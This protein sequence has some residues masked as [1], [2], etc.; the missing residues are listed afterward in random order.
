MGESAKWVLGS[1]AWVAAVDWRGAF[2]ARCNHTLAAA[3][4]ARVPS[5][6][7]CLTLPSHPCLATTTH[8]Q[9]AQA[10]S[11]QETNAAAASGAEAQLREARE[12]GARE[13]RLAERRAAEAEEEQTRW[14][15][16]WGGAIGLK[17]SHLSL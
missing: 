13:V 17:V 11:S 8:A 14:V 5:P 1:D 10:S 3:L 4:G 16:G 9:L 12:R 2:R 7:L 6:S 15:G